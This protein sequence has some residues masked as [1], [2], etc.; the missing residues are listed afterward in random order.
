[1]PTPSRR[2]R[3]AGLRRPGSGPGEDDPREEQVEAVSPAGPEQDIGAAESTE[4]TTPSQSPSPSPRPSPRRKARDAGVAK[5][6]SE[7]EAGSVAAEQTEPEAVEPPTAT[8]SAA[9]AGSGRRR[10]SPKALIAALLIVAVAFAGLAVFFRIEGNEATA[11]TSNEALLD[12]AKTAQVK[13]EVST[14]VERLFSY[15]FN[16]IAKT[17]NAA[18]ELLVT[19]EVRQQY[20]QQFAE[21]KRLAPEQKMVVTTTVTRSGVIMLDG[22]RA[23]VLLFADQTSTRT[24]QDQTSAG[25]AQLS[26]NAEL[27]DGKWKITNIDTYNDVPQPPPAEQGQPAPAPGK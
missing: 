12:A 8:D 3:V 6:A 15:D 24:D 5:P 14:A 16:D 2:P 18:K 1:M 20:E 26:V 25:G 11:A 9:T 7:A 21:V 23:K 17:E 4:P 19:D 10:G 27:R 22:D 13:E